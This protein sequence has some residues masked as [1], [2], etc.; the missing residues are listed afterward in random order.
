MLKLVKFLFKI[1]CLIYLIFLKEGF[2]DNQKLPPIFYTPIAISIIHFLIFFLA[3]NLIIRFTQMIYRKR[4]RK[5]DKYSDNVIIGLQNIY[6]LLMVMA[7][8][9]TII[10]FFGIE[11]SKLLTALSIVAAAIAIISKEFVSDII[12]GMSITFSK[13]L[14]IGDYVKVGEY[15][16]G[17]IDINLHKIVLHHDDDDIIYIP[18]SKAYNDDIINYTQKEIR[19]FNVDF[20][21]NS[22]LNIPLSALQV[23]IHR[24]LLRYN[25]SIVLDSEKLKVINILKDEIRYKLQFKLNQMNPIL[26]EQIKSEIREAISLLVI[27]N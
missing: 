4:K 14:S 12:A 2:L 25:D 26:A 19:K 21:I 9:V 24:V 23:T 17:V 13:E 20:A 27:K 3:V 16:G 15:K 22:E 18:N 8:T 1:V 10:G 6:Y 11:F 5:G 7:I